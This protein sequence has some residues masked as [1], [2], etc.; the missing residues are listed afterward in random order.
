ML[1]VAMYSGAAY[2]YVPITR[3]EICVL[4]AIGPNFAIP[5]SESLA[6]YDWDSKLDQCQKNKTYLIQIDFTKL[7]YFTFMIV[8]Y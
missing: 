2:P 7:I 8:L 3:V 1:P 4:L 5:K 6:S